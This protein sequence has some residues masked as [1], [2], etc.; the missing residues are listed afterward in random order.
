MLE[1]RSECSFFR[2]ASSSSLLNLA[3]DADDSTSSSALLGL[4]IEGTTVAGA[5]SRDYKAT[6]SREQVHKYTQLLVKLIH[7]YF[8]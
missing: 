3:P 4:R 6:S 1:T 5:S 8:F 7:Q 2:M